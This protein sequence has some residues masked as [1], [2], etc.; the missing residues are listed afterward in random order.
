MLSGTISLSKYWLKLKL[1]STDLLVLLVTESLATFMKN[2]LNSSGLKYISEH[3]F[4]DLLLP[5]FTILHNAF[6]LFSALLIKLTFACFFASLILLL[7]KIF[8]HLYSSLYQA[9]FLV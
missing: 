2:S 6:V 8:T 1:L 5:L 3:S 9:I 4:V 7:Y